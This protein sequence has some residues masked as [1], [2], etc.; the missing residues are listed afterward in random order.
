LYLIEN[1]GFIVLGC[2][3]TKLLRAW[4]LWGLWLFAQIISTELSTGYVENARQ[5]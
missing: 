5:A 2:F 4:A 1:H 3:L